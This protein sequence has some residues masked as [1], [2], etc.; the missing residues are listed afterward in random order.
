MDRFL[1][2]TDT[3]DGPF[4]RFAGRGYYPRYYQ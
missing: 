2:L 3:L 1:V 4:I